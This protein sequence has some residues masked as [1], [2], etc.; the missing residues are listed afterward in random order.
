M[1]SVIW[2]NKK[3]KFA[4]SRDKMLPSLKELL[5]M[6]K[7]FILLI[8]PPVFFRSEDIRSSL[9]YFWLMFTNPNKL[10]LE[11]PSIITSNIIWFALPLVAEWFMRNKE[12]SLDI[13]H[14]NKPLRWL[15]YIVIIFLIINYGEFQNKQFIYFQF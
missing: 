14:L 4:I 15:I 7:N 9:E 2:R 12:H 11:F 10:H 3:N 1:P 5:H 13:A 8:I 6:V